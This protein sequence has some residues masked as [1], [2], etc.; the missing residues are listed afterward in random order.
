MRSR[1]SPIGLCS[2][3]FIT[4]FDY[5]DRIV[6]E[7]EGQGRS[8]LNN[9]AIRASLEDAMSDKLKAFGVNQVVSVVASGNDLVV[10][11]H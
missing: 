6:N 4:G 1:C 2:F 8:I 3:I 9:N 10:Q 7:V 5:K 11:Y